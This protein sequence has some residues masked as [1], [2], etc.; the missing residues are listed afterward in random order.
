MDG[1]I[2][3][4]AALIIIG[5]ARSTGTTFGIERVPGPRLPPQ[6]MTRFFSHSAHS[7][8]GRLRISFSNYFFNCYSLQISRRI[9]QGLAKNLND[10][11]STE[12]TARSH[13]RS[14]V[15]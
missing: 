10:P 7:G 4:T 13:Y 6:R 14:R 9:P 5:R 8:F 3:W 1:N 2:E 11:I 15:N 12:L